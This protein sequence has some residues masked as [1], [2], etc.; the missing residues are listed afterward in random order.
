MK[1][2]H[3]LFLD[4]LADAYDAEK[5]L[6]KALPKVAKAADDAD[7]RNAIESHLDETEEQVRLL[8]MILKIVPEPPES[9]KCQAMHGLLKEVEEL[10]AEFKDSPAI[11]AAIIAAAQKVEHYEIATY[12]TLLE[13]ANQLDMAEAAEVFEAILQ[14][15]KAADVRLTRLA[16]G[17]VNEAAEEESTELGESAGADSVRRVR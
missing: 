15:E 8:E 4:Q 10:I 6:T 5:Q 14:Q 12:G 13:W 9:K 3:Q 11:D 7:L 17:S 1:S 2:F 16:C